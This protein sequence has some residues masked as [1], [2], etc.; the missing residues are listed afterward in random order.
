MADPAQE[1]ILTG[2]IR[3][4]DDVLYRVGVD[5]LAIARVDG[6]SLTL[7]GPGASIWEI[8]QGPMTGGS[9][10]SVLA[11]EYEVPHETVACDIGPVLER[12]VSEGFLDVTP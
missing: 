12:M 11:E 6:Y 10:V 3:R 5:F 8:L 2:T 1:E 4:R 7:T 9:V